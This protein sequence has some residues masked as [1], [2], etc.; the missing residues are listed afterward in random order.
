MTMLKFAT[1]RTTI[2]GG[3]G[4]K[5]K[6][7]TALFVVVSSWRTYWVEKEEGAKECSSFAPRSILLSAGRTDADDD[8]VKTALNESR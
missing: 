8:E 7:P 1:L 4:G 5:E 6:P 2:G 3:G